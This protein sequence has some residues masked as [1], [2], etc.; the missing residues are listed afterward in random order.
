MH[1]LG[2]NIRTKQYE[3]DQSRRAA[4]QPGQSIWDGGLAMVRKAC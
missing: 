2:S 1:S 4:E 3:E